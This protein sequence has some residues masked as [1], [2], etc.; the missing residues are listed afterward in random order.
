MKLYV[1]DV[2]VVLVI[3]SPASRN[4]DS[5]PPGRGIRHANSLLLIAVLAGGTRGP[6]GFVGAEQ[7][8]SRGA[9]VI[10]AAFVHY[11]AAADNALACGSGGRSTLPF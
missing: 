1:I 10:T 8:L 3:F 5:C 9:S 11:A 4:S 2:C 6:T 7:E